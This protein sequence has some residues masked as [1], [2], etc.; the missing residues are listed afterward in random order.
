MKYFIQ[1]IPILALF[2]SISFTQTV[3]KT[4]TTA[5]QFLKIGIGARALGMGGAY[6]AVSND[7]TALY[8]NP[9]GLAS[10]KKNEIILDH[11]D[12]ILDVDLDFIGGSYNTPFGTI[13][14]AISA[15]Y[16]GE[17]EVTTTHSPEGT[18]EK[19]NAGSIMGQLTFSRSLTDRF[20]FGISTKIIRESIYNSKANGLALDLGT[21][22][23][24]Q[25]PGLTMGMSISNYGTKMQMEGRDLLLQTEVDPSLESDPININANFA[26][27]RFELPLIF[28]FGLA[29]K[30]SLPN[31]LSI[32][33]AVDALHPN[34]NTESINLGSE[35]TFKDF[36]FLRSGLANLYQRDSISGVSIGC[37]IKLK[38]SNT[39]YHIDY[40]YVDMGPLG[41]PKKITLT[42]SL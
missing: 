12:W 30:K 24:T 10:I 23:D 35:L 17:M 31:N 9:A 7:A 22:Y 4:G 36:L 34:D 42:T 19:F 3:S 32:L 11:Q 5:A 38:I 15:M 26:T 16:M 37:G 20:S 25:I 21:L 18:G 28:R 6:S 33:F 41:N 14:A 29:Y 39:Y 40:T 1:T 2:L 27:D 8:W 13:G